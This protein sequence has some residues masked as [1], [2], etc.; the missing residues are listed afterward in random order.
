MHPMYKRGNAVVSTDH[1][2]GP[3]RAIGRV[4]AR[5]CL[6]SNISTR[7]LDLARWFIF[8]LYWSRSKVKDLKI[9]HSKVKIQSR[10]KKDA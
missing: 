9:Q 1:F 7:H 5:T 8:T 3:D 6:D 4:C 10:I 2:N